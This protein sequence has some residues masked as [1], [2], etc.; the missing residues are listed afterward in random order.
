MVKV[1]VH[2]T[3]PS[4]GHVPRTSVLVTGSLTM[5]P[6]NVIPMARHVRVRLGDTAVFGNAPV[7]PTGTWRYQGN[8]PAD[9][10]DGAMLRLLVEGDG[11]YRYNNG[12]TEPLD[13]EPG[14]AELIVQ[15]ETRPPELSI[16]PG[17]ATD[18]VVPPGSL[19][20][21]TVQ[22]TSSGALS[23]ITEV[24]FAVANG[25]SG[26]AENLSGDW[27]SWSA[28]F[29]LGAGDHQFAITAKDSS[30]REASLPGVISVHEQFERTDPD[31]AFGLCGSCAISRFST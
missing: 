1:D 28:R 8:V 18:V 4:G 7:S 20:T 31:K 10:A 9:V 3:S 26:L 14:V 27:T 16:T 19:F 21:S 22:G 11:Q 25:P 29:S 12:S 15:V 5:D 17:Y 24:R 13:A 6:G 23:G 2:I 30:G